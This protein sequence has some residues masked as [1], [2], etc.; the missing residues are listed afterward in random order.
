MGH[1]KVYWSD[2]LESLAKA[3]FLH[4]TDRS[5]P[6]E[7]QCTVVGSPTMAGWLKQY[8]LYDLPASEKKQKVLACWDFQ[9]LHPFVNDWLAKASMGTD[10]GQRNPAQHPY[11][12]A[13]LPWRIWTILCKN[14]DNPAYAPLQDYIGNDPK[15]QDRKRWGLSQRLAKLF[16]DYQNYRPDLL[17][18]W[19]QGQNTN[20]N[21]NVLWQAALWR[22]LLVTE[23]E[24]Y[25]D[26]FLSMNQTL[27]ACG[28]TETYRR[29]S[30]F[31]TSSMP[32]A[33]MQFFAELGAIMPVE[34]YIFNP[35]QTF[36]IDEPTLKQ[37][38]RALIQNGDDL[39]W[40]DPPHA[41]LSGFGR[42]TQAFLATILDT[43]PADIHEPLWTPH[44]HASRLEQVQDDIRAGENQQTE[45]WKSDASIQFHACHS[46]LREVEVAKDII[47]KWF[48]ENA[49][50]DP[51][52]RDVQ[53]LIP[54]METYAPF[55]ESVFQVSEPDAPIPC[56]FS[57]RPAI[58]AGAVG[59]AFTKLMQFNESRMS[60]P[61]AMELL[62]LEPVRL[63]YD[64]EPD[65][66]AEIRSLV[67]EAN[68][69]WGRDAH[70]I[71]QTLNPQPSTL[72]VPRSPAKRDDGR[73]PSTLNPQ[74]STL[75]PTV[76]WRRG[77]DRLIAGLAIGHC[78]EDDDIIHAGKLGTLR[79][80]DIV[81]GRN[82]QLVGK[83]SQF[84]GDLCVTAEEIAIPQRKVSEWIV[85]FRAMLDRFFAET[86]HAFRE[87]AEIR[88]GMMTI[89]NAATI[90][91]NPEVPA[92]IV[93]A[94]I[95]S[96]LS[97]MTRGGKSDANAV[98]FS[99]MRTMEVTPRK[100]IIL[101]G[102][103][104]GV[105]PRVDQRPAFDLLAI[106]P[107]YGDQSLRYEDRLAFLEAIM[108]ARER[109]VITY[110]GRNITNNKEIPPSP[111]V[112]EFL[113]YLHASHY[114]RKATTLQP[115]EHKL[116]GF[117]PAY[118]QNGSH[119]FSYSLTNYAAA[120]TL[121]GSETQTD[122]AA[123]KE[124]PL[125][126]PSPSPRSV[127]T[128]AQVSL[129]TLQMFFQNPARYFYTKILDIRLLD[130]AHDDVQD[131][132]MFDGDTLD[133]YKLKNVIIRDSLAQTK[134]HADTRLVPDDDYLSRLQEQSLIPLGTFGYRK[135]RQQMLAIQ[136]FLHDE[137]IPESEKNIYRALQDHEA[138]KQDPTAIALNIGN[139]E[140]TANLPICSDFET[141]RRSLLFFRYASIKPKDCLKAW[142]AHLVGHA[143][144]E[145]FETLIL[146]K[147]SSTKISC[148]R[149]HPMEQVKA[150]H[151][152]ASILEL[153]AAGSQCVIPFSP[154]ASHA[155]AEKI[156]KN[157]DVDKAYDAATEAWSGFGFPEANDVYLYA[158]W[159]DEGPM[160]HPHFI[161]L[162]LA[163]WQPFFHL[164][165]KDTGADEPDAEAPA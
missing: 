18:T 135:A 19:K 47:L 59:T 122:R 63:R 78:L 45:Q 5:D 159:G 24:S 55:I 100:L 14:A 119:L 118:Y 13:V 70:H 152:L 20:L 80:T 54:D 74:P 134:D 109:L 15:S 84:Y 91:G 33:Y 121:A 79:V 82:A 151:I 145:I 125:G 75:P 3:M 154:V 163:F 90:S 110:T 46:P 41:L 158:V 58:G 16:D 130:P 7:T 44:K 115:I 81:E 62:E 77:L 141:A 9:M 89:E 28:I 17:H 71:T 64:L 38:L 101:L 140:I 92:A 138:A 144:G 49:D 67:H 129:E 34:M 127:D 139:Y 153:Y 69:R 143:A 30:V 147:D 32:K 142:L 150:S 102:L 162:A 6:F 10:I 107:R 21:M 2:S 76:T 132:E 136:A 11:S 87:I 124:E 72:P 149:L 61:E 26:Q 94:A 93:A 56:S 131:S 108:S 116:H 133:D 48:D 96:Q 83:L 73:T 103:N 60:A 37:H 50:S 106:K 157:D 126:R 120:C 156:E 35:S 23:P 57:R 43:T 22:E 165:A 97:S 104:E 111:A 98:M 146:G 12:T 68:I 161:R 27:P 51:Q 148:E 29:I 128:P 36:W 112:T 25:L 117:N 95:E 123:S 42:G 85:C 31:H 53:V 155:Y 99:P 1:L 113:Q 105:F 66:V 114:E 164:T 40:M 88:R 86:D 4:T 39:P 137:C 160:Q 65:A 8:F 52:P